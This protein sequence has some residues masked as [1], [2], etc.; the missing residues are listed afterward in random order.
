MYGEVVAGIDGALF[1]E[2]L[3]ELRGRA[4]RSATATTTTSARSS[5]RSTSIYQDRDRHRLPAGPA[6]AAA[7]RSR[8]ASSTPGTLRAPRCIAPGRHLRR[9]R[10]C[11][12]R[13][14]DGVREPRRALGDR[15]LLQPRSGDRRARPLRRVPADAQGEDIVAGTRTPLPI[16][17]MREDPARGATAQLEA[18]V[19]SL[20]HHY[21]DMQDVEFTIESEQLLPA[22]DPR[23]E[24]HGVGS[25]RAPRSTWS[26]EGPAHEERG[27]PADRPG[28]DRAA[29]ASDDRPEGEARVVATGLCRFA[30]RRLRHRHLRRGHCG[31]ARCGRRGRRP[32][33]AGDDRGRHPRPPRRARACSPRA[34]G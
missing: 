14:A 17:E 6:R 33:P 1:A 3:D 23:R 20:E 9:R 24:A 21:R 28:A 2:A 30:G 32:R 25:A 13:R 5:V 10:H 31:R 16:A 22:A 4:K 8:R 12:E 19:A 15:R 18:A 27:R 11:R 26:S 34:A 7:H 29:A